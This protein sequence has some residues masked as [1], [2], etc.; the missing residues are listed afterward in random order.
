L[1]RF[2]GE[3]SSVKRR[4]VVLAGGFEDV[5]YVPWDEDP[6]ET[7]VVSVLREPV[8]AGKSVPSLGEA[9]VPFAGLL[10]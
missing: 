3:L 6:P 7:R 4:P 5:S 1:R 10:G 9:V 2:A 8:S